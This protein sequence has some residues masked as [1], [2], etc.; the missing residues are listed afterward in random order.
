MNDWAV[1]LFDDFV[2]PI[3]VAIMEAFDWIGEPLSPTKF[4]AMSGDEDPI[5][6]TKASHHF[7][8]LNTYGLLKIVELRP[9]RGAT[10]VIYTPADAESTQ[11]WPG[12][13][14]A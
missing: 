9:V 4:A 5:P 3:Q 8:V 13:A 6:V 10:E 1:A 12:I 2:H 7:R 11:G 14:K